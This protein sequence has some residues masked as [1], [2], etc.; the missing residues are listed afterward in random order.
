MGGD[1]P[2]V[3]SGTPTN[4]NFKEYIGDERF[5]ESGTPEILDSRV[6]YDKG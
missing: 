6:W 1:N 3:G 2:V 4:L 5:S